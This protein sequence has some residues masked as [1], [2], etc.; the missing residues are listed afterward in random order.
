MD[1]GKYACPA[2]ASRNLVAVDSIVDVN[3]REPGPS[4]RER[5][6]AEQ[7]DEDS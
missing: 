1:A 3:D 7:V 4:T 6:R 2:A 5:S